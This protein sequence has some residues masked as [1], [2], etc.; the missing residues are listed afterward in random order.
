ME[1]FPE[2][3]QHIL[4]LKAKITGIGS[5]RGSCPRFMEKML[6]HATGQ[7]PNHPVR[8]NNGPLFISIQHTKWLTKYSDVIC[9][10][11]KLA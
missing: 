4:M 5:T 9:K 11:S 3:N 7:Q 8:R 6:A 1:D 2:I 10:I